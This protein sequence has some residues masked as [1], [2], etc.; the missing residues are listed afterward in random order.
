M[1]LAI[2]RAGPSG[3]DSRVIDRE[4]VTPYITEQGAAVLLPNWEAIYG[5]IDEMFH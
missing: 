2:L 1:G 4:M 5:L 3:F